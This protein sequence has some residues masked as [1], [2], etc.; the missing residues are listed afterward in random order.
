L[1][2]VVTTEYHSYWG[3]KNKFERVGQNGSTSSKCQQILGVKGCLNIGEH[4][5][6]SFDNNGLPV[7]HEGNAYLKLIVHSC[8]KPGCSLC[9]KRGWAVREAGAS[10]DKFNEASK[11]YGLPQHIILSVPKV[12]YRLT[13]EE[14][15]KN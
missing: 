1:S 13:Y 2:E 10:E 5:H 7:N 8:D 15:K 14:L 11:K 6:T 12:D 4:N 3:D 9:M